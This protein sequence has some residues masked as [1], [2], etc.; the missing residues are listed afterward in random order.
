MLILRRGGG[1]IYRLLDA[2][3]EFVKFQ[4]TVIK[5]GGETKAILH[6]AFFPRAVGIH[7]ADLR[8]RNMTFIDKK[9]EIL[10]KIIKQGHRRTADGTSADYAGI[11]FDAGAKAKLLHHFNIVIG[12]LL[13]TLSLN[14]L[15]VFFKPRNTLVALAA[16]FL[17]C[18]SHLLLGGYIVAGGINGNVSQNARSLSGHGVE[19]TYAVDLVAEKLNADGNIV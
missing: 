1:D 11:V 13:D 17:N 14:E 9:H 7:G 8:Q 4:R 3:T 18:G 5:G 12:A 10:R 15:A 19:L 2:L 16:N 6:K